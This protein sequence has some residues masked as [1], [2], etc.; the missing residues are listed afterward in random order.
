[1]KGVEI[2]DSLLTLLFRVL[3]LYLSVLCAIRLLGKRTM[4]E[5]TPTDRVSGITLGT[6]AGAVAVTLKTP[7]LDGV[8]AVFGFSLMAWLFGVVLQHI[9][10]LRPLL[11]GRARELVSDGK[12]LADA[13]KSAGI[14]KE[15]LVMR[16][17]EGQMPDAQHVALATLEID[18]RLGIIPMSSSTGSSS[19]KATPKA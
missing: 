11:L 12:V 8:I 4:A 10:S 6:I 9:P 16:L 13:L 19:T 2:I 5:L 1:M 18:G 3:V 14:T 7:L 15:D 17:H